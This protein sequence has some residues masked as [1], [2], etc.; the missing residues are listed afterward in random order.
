LLITREAR[1]PLTVTGGK[2]HMEEPG[3]DSPQVDEPRPQAL[4]GL[5]TAVRPGG[6]LQPTQ[7]SLPWGGGV[8]APRPSPQP[9]VIST[10]LAL[11]STV[12]SLS[13]CLH[14]L[15]L[16][17]TPLQHHWL[18]FCSLNPDLLWDICLVLLLPETFPTAMSPWLRLRCSVICR[19][20]PQAP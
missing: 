14:P 20:N 1:S 18:P 10:K 3:Q 13:H 11:C 2:C 9:V 7:S 4:P 5:H 15:S 12:T 6:G 16:S 8:R 17:L 19:A